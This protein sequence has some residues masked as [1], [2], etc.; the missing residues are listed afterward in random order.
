MSAGVFG[1]PGSRLT[2][3]RVSLLWRSADCPQILVA[4]GDTFLFTLAVFTTRP[5]R[6]LTAHGPMVTSHNCLFVLIL[7]AHQ[8]PPLLAM[9]AP[10][11]I[12]I[13]NPALLR[14]ALP[15]RDK[16]PVCVTL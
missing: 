1:P 4:S 12:T 3:A 5:A 15:P 13:A 16:D 7:P 6:T 10:R 9:P 11:I 8:G 2:S 14:P